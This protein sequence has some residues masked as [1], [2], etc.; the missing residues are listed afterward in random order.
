MKAVIPVL[1]LLVALCLPAAVV[2]APQSDVYNEQLMEMGYH[3]LHL[4][5]INAINGIS[6]TRKQVLELREMCR[7][8][9]KAGG[10]VPKM[11]EPLSPDLLEVRKTYVELAQV[12]TSGKEPS[13]DLKTRV[14]KAR[15]TEA[16]WIRE[17]VSVKPTARDTGDCLKCHLSP[18][19]VAEIKKANPNAANDSPL[20]GLGLYRS[21]A[22]HAEGD[23]AHSV[24]VLGKHGAAQV[25][26]LADKVDAL[27]S[28]AQKDVIGKFSCCLIP[29]KDMSDPV[30]AG[31]AEASE[32]DLKLLRWARTVPAAQWP[33]AKEKVLDWMSQV[34][35]ATKPGSTEAEIAAYRQKV[36]TVL[37]KTRKM[38]DTEFE[39]QKEGLCKE[40]N[41]RK[42]QVV[43][44]NVAKF[45]RAFFLL[46]PGSSGVYDALLQRLPPEGK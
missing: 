13:D 43:P 7:E 23:K 15:K 5:S 31:Q 14:A 3:I 21:P 18:A 29:P 45:K 17:S 25:S 1:A 26:R 24:G 22:A 41:L 28:D 10:Y 12:L 33:G 6:L 2:S 32:N 37:E 44:P 11:Q 42:E 20:E 8:V 36:E 4:S 30:R 46:M 19:R 16:E 27:L 39:M 40:I 35:K 34:I 38:S 9:E